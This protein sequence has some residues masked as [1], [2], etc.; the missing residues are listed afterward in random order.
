MTVIRGLAY[1]SP[2]TATVGRPLSGSTRRNYPPPASQSFVPVITNGGLARFPRHMRATSVAAS[3]GMETQQGGATAVDSGSTSAQPMKLLFVEMGVGYDQHGWV[4]NFYQV[5]IKG[6]L[7]FS[8]RGEMVI[9][10]F[11][12]T[13]FDSQDITAAAMRACRDAISSNS[14]P[15]FRR[16][17]EHLCF[18]LSYDFGCDQTSEYD[19]SRIWLR[20]TTNVLQ[21]FFDC[22]IMHVMNAGSIPGVTFGQMK[23]QIKLGVPH[24]LQH[25]LDVERV[26]SV[27]P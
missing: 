17:I 1:V 15:A 21:N 14:I 23:L 2:S 22:V 18:L 19:V 4:N 20:G 27:F 13:V 5:P 8:W 26:K 3:S 12:G 6:T 11:C 25:S 24:S 9:W 16:G 7:C 10:D